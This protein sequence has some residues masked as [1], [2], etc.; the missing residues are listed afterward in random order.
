MSVCPNDNL[1]VRYILPK[2]WLDKGD[3]LSVIRHC[4]KHEEDYSPEIIYTYPLALILSGESGKAELLLAEAKTKF[5]LVAKELIKKRHSKPK[6][7]VYGGI[8]VGGPDQ[9]YEYWKQYGKYWSKSA[10]A[11]ELISRI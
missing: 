9:A 10:Q 4:K 6:S 7:S 5:P 1:G 3:V 2:L 11:M 8:T